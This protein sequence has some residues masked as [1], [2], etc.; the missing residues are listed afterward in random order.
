MN[1]IIYRSTPGVMLIQNIIIYGV[2]RKGVEY[3]GNKQICSQ[4]NK[5]K[6]LNFLYFTDVGLYQRTML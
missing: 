1:Q 5:H 3:I 6:T 4:T 2:D